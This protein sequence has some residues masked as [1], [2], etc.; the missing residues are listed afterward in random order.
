MVQ[1]QPKKFPNG[2]GIT[3]SPG[4]VW[5]HPALNYHLG[6]PWVVSHAHFPHIPLDTYMGGLKGG[7]ILS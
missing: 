2:S 1:N 7:L 3:R 5:K 6:Y 4:L